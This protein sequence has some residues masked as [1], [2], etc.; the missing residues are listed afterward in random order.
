MIKRILVA[1][2]GT[3]FTPVAVRYALELAKTHGASVTGVTL[4]NLEALTNVGPI[5][6]GGGAAAIELAQHRQAVTEERIEQAIVDFETA[7]RDAGMIHCV[8]RET[9]D[10]LDR[11][12][13][14]WRYHDLTIFGLR[15]LF[16]YGVV[17][18]PDD[19]IIRLIREGVRPLIAVPDEH[20]SIKHAVIAYNGSMG[21]AKAMKRFVQSRLW[22]DV[23]LSLVTFN[24]RFEEGEKLLADAAAYCE[25]HGFDPARHVVDASPRKGL[26]AF[27]GEQAADLIVMGSTARSRMTR[28]VLGDTA[29][30]TI[31]D[32]EIPLYLAR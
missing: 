26:L 18:N 22:P 4:V 21:S 25:A 31:R 20:R 27:G 30:H 19:V 16:E 2:S 12:V 29:M 17:H 24:S 9:G 6:V 32:A 8:D 11:L 3:S 13:S 5:P 28:Y 1:L 23:R 14:L 7:C 10:P 15:G